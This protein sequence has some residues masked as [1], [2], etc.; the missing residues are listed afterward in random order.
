MDCLV[1]VAELIFVL[2]K[3]AVV[4]PLKGLLEKLT[5]LKVEWK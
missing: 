4:S 1:G 3:G 5:H 2:L